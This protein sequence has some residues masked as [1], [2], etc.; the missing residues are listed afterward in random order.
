MCGI[1]G[2]I[3]LGDRPLPDPG[4]IQRM[5]RS[6]VHRG[7]DGE[8]SYSD[9]DLLLGMVRLAVIDPEHGKQP[10]FGC[11]E[12]VVGVYNGEIYNHHDLR[13]DLVA[14]GHHVKDRCDSSILPHLF[15][16]NGI[17]MVSKLRGMFA[18]ALWDKPRRILHLTRDRV[19]I[20]PLF[21]AQTSDFLV[22][23]SEIKGIL[24]SGL[25]ETEIDRDALDDLFSFSWPC[26]P[27]T[28]FSGISSL[29]P[30]HTLSVR[31][32]RAVEAPR[33]WWR[34]EIP[35]RG[36]HLKGSPKQ[37]EI[38]FREQLQDAVKCHLRADV[39]V[40]VYLSGGLDSSAI[41]MLTRQAAETSPLALS[42]GFDDP[43]Y[44]ESQ[45]AAVVAQA[46]QLPM[47]LIKS[48]AQTA[49]V[50]PRALW[51][52]ELPLMVPVSTSGFELSAGTRA[53]GVPVVLTG[54]GADE[55]LGGYDV[56]KA[57]KMRRAFE[58]PLLRWLKRPVCRQ[59]YKMA[60]APEGAVEFMLDVEARGA[61]EIEA[62]FGGAYP[63]WYG[64]WQA[65]DIDRD[66]LLGRGGR[67]VRPSTEPPALWEHLLPPDLER[68]DPLDAAI[69]IEMNTRLPAWILMIS[70]R[71]SMANSIEA[72]VPFLDH[73]VLELTA[74]MPPSLKMKGATEKYLLRR[75]MHGRMP[76]TIRKRAKQPFMTPIKE[77]FFSDQRPAYVDERLSKE[78]LERS[79]IFEPSVV[80]RLRS[81]LEAGRSNLLQ[82]ER[83]GMI[84]MLVLGVQL[85]QH[86]FI[87]NFDVDGPPR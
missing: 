37:L 16:E 80:L 67:R 53:Q 60:R 71:C 52:M 32:G 81:G 83:L 1:V 82:T 19:G 59:L 24:A 29:P 41:A 66:E 4:I 39:P 17:E 85:L 10:V 77:W 69:A 43:Q 11:N 3:R 42:I 25:V 46:A 74:Q 6:I 5:C 70:D 28:M 22:F 18:F 26:P 27:R 84:L 38:Q 57:D 13:R 21:Y 65:L 23:A 72:R 63:V 34:L 49:Q 86:L 12:D 33:R 76:E 87:D 14:G 40:G 20:K 62:A 56:F 9:E 50:Y 79:G 2:I 48:T 51:H 15:E 35:P 54:D 30:A 68:L 31:A 73:H 36:E 7:P 47:H 78:A 61:S 58:R 64:F 75:A 45:H 55:I 44:D 8:Y